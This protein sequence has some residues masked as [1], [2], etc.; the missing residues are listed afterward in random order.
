MLGMDCNGTTDRLVSVV[1]PT[2]ER[3]EYLEGAIRTA[4][5]QSHESIEVIV[6]DDGSTNQYAREIVDSFPEIVT[7]IQHEKNKGLS[8][9]RNTGIKKSNGNF[10]A[11]LDDDD[12]WHRKKLEYQ[13]SALDQDHKVGLATCLVASITPNN[14]IVHCETGAPEGDCSEKILIGN[15]IGTPSRVLIRKECFGEIG[16]FDE[17][18]PTKQDWDL[19][20]RLCQEWNVVAVED[21]LCFRTIHESMSSSPESARRDNRTIL[22]KHETLLRNKGCWDQAQAEIEDRVGRGFLRQK[23]LQTSRRHFKKALQKD[24]TVG[25]VLLYFL[26][27]THPA[28]VERL[29]TIKREV[30]IRMSDCSNQNVL[31]GAVLEMNPEKT[32]DD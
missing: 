10:I 30:S 28:I 24:P 19:Y 20:L 4:L 29:R 7:C 13:V 6:V 31:D 11:F 22:E 18:L 2:Y 12:R 1:I 27:L 16:M 9:A 14:N 3:P 25:R 8:A 32:R 26:T 15:I 5:K 17:S 23:D 21:H